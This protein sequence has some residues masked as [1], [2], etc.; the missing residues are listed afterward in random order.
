MATQSL[1]DVLGKQMGSDNTAQRMHITTCS[2]L[3]GV[4]SLV[5]SDFLLTCMLIHEELLLLRPCNV[6]DTA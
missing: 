3:A 6:L 2:A 5:S 4:A 1:S